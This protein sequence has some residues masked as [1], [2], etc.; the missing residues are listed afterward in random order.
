MRVFNRED[1]FRDIYISGHPRSGNNYLVCLI[2]LNFFDQQ[3]KFDLINEIWIQFNSTHGIPLRERLH[4][5]LFEQ[6]K[7]KNTKII[8]IKRNFGDVSRSVYNLR[9]RLD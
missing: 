6:D 4:R 7:F 1:N 8:H 3:K 5:F 2:S 9:S